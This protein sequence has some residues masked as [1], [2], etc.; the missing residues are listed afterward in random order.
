[1][2]ELQDSL[3]LVSRGV[4]I[5]FHSLIEFFIFVFSRY[6]E[7]AFFFWVHAAIER[8]VRSSCVCVVAVEYGLGEL[9]LGNF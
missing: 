1:M 9:K 2:V 5:I 8:M 3:L 4:H 6:L 7:L